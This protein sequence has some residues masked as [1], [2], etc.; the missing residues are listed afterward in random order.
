MGNV[1]AFNAD[2][3]DLLP[4]GINVEAGIKTKRRKI[5]LAFSTS[6]HLATLPASTL[7]L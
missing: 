1:S 2:D 4:H 7:I 6:M 5:T 3:G